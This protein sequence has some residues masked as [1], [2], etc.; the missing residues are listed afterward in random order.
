M[1]VFFACLT[2]NGQV[3]VHANGKYF[4]YNGTKVYYEDTGKG[5][6]LLLLHNFYGTAD[7]WQPYINAYSK[8][9]RTIAVDMIGHGRSDIYKR[10]VHFKHADYA[11]II[12]ALLDSLKLNKVNAVGASSGQPA[13]RDVRPVHID[14][15]FEI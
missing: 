3:K 13:T 10:D 14:F 11:K 4:H 1:L 7:Y 8:Q 12:I 9:F 5:E 2:T 6:P 15:Y